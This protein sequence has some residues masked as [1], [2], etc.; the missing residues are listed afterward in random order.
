MAVV[1]Y[2]QRRFTALDLDFHIALA[3]ASGNSLA[4]DLIT[5]IRGQLAK[6]LSRVLAFPN[7]GPLSLEE[8]V[9]IIQ[10]IQERNP[11][12]ARKAMYTHLHAALNRYRKTVKRESSAVM[13]NEITAAHQIKAYKPKSKQSGRRPTVSKR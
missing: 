3:K 6:A 1:Q 9:R 11:E 8:H 7:A 12:G 2:D 5:M 10:K 4:A 13:V